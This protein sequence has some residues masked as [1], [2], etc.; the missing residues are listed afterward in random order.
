M[1]QEPRSSG[2]YFIFT[3]TVLISFN[4]SRIDYN[5]APALT[6]SQLE[7]TT[8]SVELQQRVPKEE[9]PYEESGHDEPIL[10]A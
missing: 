1:T 5:R 2:F 4:N 6:A 10:R 7:L 8:S 3:T 9:R